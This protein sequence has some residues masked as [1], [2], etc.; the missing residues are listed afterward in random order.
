MSGR[1]TTEV[2]HLVRRLVEQHRKRKKNLHMVFI[3]LEKAYDK[4][5]KEVLSRCMEASDIHVAYITVIKDMHE[6]AK[7][8]ARTTG[9]DSD[10]IPVEIGLH[11]ESAL[12]LFLFAVA[13]EVTT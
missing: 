1:S 2:I 5:P 7:T 12:R 13:L 6:G 3:D 9:G 8:R 10:H 4:V 11:Q